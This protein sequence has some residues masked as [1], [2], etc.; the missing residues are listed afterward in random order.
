M[1]LNQEAKRDLTSSVH[2]F[3][4]GIQEVGGATF[5]PTIRYWAHLKLRDHVRYINFCERF[6]EQIFPKTHKMIS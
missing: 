1:K 4:Y 3:Y 6:P 5:F 2:L